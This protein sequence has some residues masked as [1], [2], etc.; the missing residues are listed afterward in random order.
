MPEQITIPIR[1]W[2]IRLG[3]A[4]GGRIST[5]EAADYVD[6]IEPLLVTHWPPAA[7]TFASLEHVASQCKYLPSYGEITEHLGDWWRRNR[8]PLAIAYE[9]PRQPEIHSA[10]ERA[11]VSWA[12]AQAVA[13]IR[14]TAQPVEDRRPKPRHLTPEQLIAAGFRRPAKHA[15]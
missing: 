1:Q 5:D 2:L 11:H 3:R 4:S 6:G 9:P 8:R 15:S 14:S 10:E 13:A 12:A 7:F